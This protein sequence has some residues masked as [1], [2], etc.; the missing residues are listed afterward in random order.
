[1]VHTDGEREDM[2]AAARRRREEERR[3]LQ[4]FLDLSARE[5]EILFLL[6]EGLS[7]QAVARRLYV[8]TSTVRMH[9]QRILRKLEVKTQVAAVA[10]TH[11]A[12]WAR[13][14]RSA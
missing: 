7:A 14:M 4:P 5:Q 1:V 8:S 10:K 11:S 13:A 9:I 3:R 6:T 12:G 2:L